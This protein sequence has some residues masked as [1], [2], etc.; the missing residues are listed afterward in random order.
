MGDRHKTDQASRLRPRFLK[1][2]ADAA[3]GCE[4]LE[5]LLFAA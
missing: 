4:V 1:G 5:M 2:S 3:T